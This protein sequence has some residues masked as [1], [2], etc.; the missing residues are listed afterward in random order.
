MT[1]KRLKMGPSFLPTVRKFCF[2]L[3]CQ[4]SRAEVSKR[5]STKLCDM[6]GSEPHFQ[7]HVKNLRGSSQ[8]W[9]AKTCLFCDG[10]HLD[11][12]YAR[13]RKI[14]QEILPTF[15]KPSPWLRY[16]R[17][18][19]APHNECKWNHQKQVACV[20]RPQKF[21]SSQW[22]RVVGRPQVAISR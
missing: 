22:H 7:M 21:Y 10:F 14:R 19:M 15:R 3:H 4:A 13:W 8:K 17:K 9:R 11:K 18:K 20:P 12:S 16:Q 5:N 1:H 6:L 2:L